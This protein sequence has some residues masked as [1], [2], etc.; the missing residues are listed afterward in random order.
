MLSGVILAG[1]EN[2]RM[3]GRVKALLPFEDSTFLQVS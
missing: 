1:G 2:R 3:N